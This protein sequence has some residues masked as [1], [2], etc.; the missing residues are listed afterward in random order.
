MPCSLLPH[1][2]S[3]PKELQSEKLWSL[4]SFV[5]NVARD[6]VI[7]FGSLIYLYFVN[8]NFSVSATESILCVLVCVTEFRVAKD[9]SESCCS[10]QY[11]P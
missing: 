10:L 5:P 4:P 11:Y 2:D 8:L 9:I 3:R 1:M 7:F 6:S